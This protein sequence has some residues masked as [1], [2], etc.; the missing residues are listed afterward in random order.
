MNFLI[1]ISYDRIGQKG[2]AGGGA[3]GSGS[4]EEKDVIV[5]D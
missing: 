5:L 4:T 1:K 3:G 2:S